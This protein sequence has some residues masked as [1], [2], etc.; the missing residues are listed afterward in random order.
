[1]PVKLVFLPERFRVVGKEAMHRQSDSVTSGGAVL[2]QDVSKAPDAVSVAV[3]LST[4]H[5]CPVGKHC[6]VCLGMCPC[7]RRVQHVAALMGCEQGAVV[8]AGGLAGGPS[9]FF[10]VVQCC[11]AWAGRA[12]SCTGLW[13][14]LKQ[15]VHPIGSRASGTWE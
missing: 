5:S 14:A 9:A 4:F 1:M 3:L 11:Q 7:H 2:L 12:S 15:D 6:S 13:C 10:G 8:W